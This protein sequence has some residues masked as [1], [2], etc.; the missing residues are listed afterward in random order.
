[1]LQQIRLGNESPDQTNA[2]E[3]QDRRTRILKQPDLRAGAHPQIRAKDKMDK[4]GK[5]NVNVPRTHQ[6]PKLLRDNILVWKIDAHEPAGRYENDEHEHTEDQME[7][8]HFAGDS[9]TKWRELHVVLNREILRV[10]VEAS[11]QLPVTSLQN[12]LL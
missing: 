8:M 12:R 5:Q 10:G 9:A 2:G 11:F 3:R 1:M 7:P 4:R 6:Q